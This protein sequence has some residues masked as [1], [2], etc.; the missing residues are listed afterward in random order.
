[1]K[2]TIMTLMAAVVGLLVAATSLVM[3][4]VGIAYWGWL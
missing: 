1:M 2:N 4:V 3:T